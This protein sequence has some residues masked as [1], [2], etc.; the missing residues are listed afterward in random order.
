[1]E[2][3]SEKNRHQQEAVLSMLASSLHP[4]IVRIMPEETHEALYSKLKRIEY[5]WV[6]YPL[7]LFFSIAHLQGRDNHTDDQILQRVLVSSLNILN[8]EK[9]RKCRGLR[10]YY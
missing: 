3:Y 7:R 1:M 9:D 5:D 4:T 10:S 2:V 8:E 6:S